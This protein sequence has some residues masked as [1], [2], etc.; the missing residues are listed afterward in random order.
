MRS[1]IT[2][3]W[4]IL[5][6]SGSWFDMSA[7][8][9]RTWLLSM[10][11]PPILLPSLQRNIL[12][13]TL[14]WATETSGGPLNWAF[15]RRSEECSF[16][17]IKTSNFIPHSCVSP[18]SKKFILQYCLMQVQR[19]IVDERGTSSVP[20]GAGDPHYWPHGSDQFPFCAPTRLCDPELSSWI[21][22][23]NR[24]ATFLSSVI[25]TTRSRST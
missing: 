15:E 5:F 20:G 12:I 8:L 14:T 25:E 2:I 19:Y 21:S 17:A 1:R 4:C 11:L 3:K 13:L 7:Q 24:Y 10:Q 16:M 18:I 6:P 22:C 23:Q 9:C